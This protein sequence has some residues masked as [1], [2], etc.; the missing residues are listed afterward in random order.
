M[1]CGEIER[2]VPEIVGHGNLWVEN[3]F[4][5]YN[6]LGGEKYEEARKFIERVFGD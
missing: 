3:T 1:E 6:D 2:F 4:N 5:K